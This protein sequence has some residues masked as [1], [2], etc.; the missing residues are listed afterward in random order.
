MMH[1]P[2]STPNL[3][4]GTMETMLLWAGS[5]TIIVV[6]YC[7]I[8]QYETRTV[9][10][11]AGLF[12]CVLAG[13]P[14]AAFSAFSSNMVVASLIHSI[15]SVMGFAAVMNVTR[16]DAHLV[17]ALARPLSKIRVIMIP[18]TV[19]VTGFVNASLPSAAGTA[20]AVGSVFIPLLISM[21]VHPAMA[22]S[23]VMAGTFG[24]MLSPGLAHNA[25]IA[26]HL[27][28]TDVMTV[29]AV[30]WKAD[31]A[32]LI[33]GALVLAVVARFRKEHAGYVPDADHQSTRIEKPNLFYAA[34]PIVPVCLLVVSA[35]ASGPQAPAWGK[36]LIAA[37]PFFKSLAVPPA[38]L[39]GVILGIAVTRTNPS[40]CVKE[41]FGGMGSIY[42]LSMGIIISA[43]VFVAGMKALGLVD[44]LVTL[45]KHSGSMAEIAA[46]VGPFFLAV[47]V[48][49]GDAATLAFNQAVSPHAEQFGMT[50]P[51]VSTLVTLTGALG[52][53]MSPLASAAIIC[54]GIA[55]VNPMA[56]SQ[57]NVFGMLAALVVS[58]IML[59]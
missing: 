16:C 28:K 38:M 32:C 6:V 1:P 51:S 15:L 42:A 4:E 11:I 53:T 23:A 59:I 52:R 58:Y 25:Y 7:L 48:G 26:Q 40:T 54:A 34:L 44:F 17:N 14:M 3:S 36:S 41:M 22:A 43:G 2:Q 20:A 12:M 55:K 57:R 18:A 37:F 31:V 13:N 21:G 8:K 30:H 29:I 27:M 5:A 49:S 45:L 56:L 47:I 33:V 35:I 46:T 10:L 39:I 24:S 50:I 9:L 19:L